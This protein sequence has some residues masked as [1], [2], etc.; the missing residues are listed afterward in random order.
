MNYY[1]LYVGDVKVSDYLLTFH[2]A[3]ELKKK[4]FADGYICEIVKFGEG[5]EHEQ[6][7]CI[8]H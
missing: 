3:L 8:F 1:S 2:E 5:D 6:H 7:G 4:I